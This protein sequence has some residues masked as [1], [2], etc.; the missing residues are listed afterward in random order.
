M[1]LV[2]YVPYAVKEVPRQGQEVVGTMVI[3][4]H[5]NKN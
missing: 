2:E 1:G 5:G 4:F 3:L